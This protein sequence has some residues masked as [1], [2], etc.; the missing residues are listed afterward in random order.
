MGLEAVS[1]NATIQDVA[2]TAFWVAHFRA[3]ENERP[4][5]LFRDPYAQQ[6]AGARGKAFA[7]AVP[8]VSRYTEWTV[9]AR[10]VIIDRFIEQAIQEGVN[11]V[12]NL[13]AGLDARPYRMNLPQNLLW[14]EADYPKI[15]EYKDDVLSSEQPSCSLIRIAIDLA[16]GGKRRAFLNDYASDAK[17]VL[18]LTEGVIPYLTSDEAAALARDLFSQTRFCYWAVE[19]IHKNVYRYL[20]D[21]ARRGGLENSPF[22]FFPKEWYA[23]FAECGWIEKE[24]RYL[25]EIAVEFKRTMPIP[26]IFELISKILPDKVKAQA[27]RSSG[28]VLFKRNDQGTRKKF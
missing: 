8:K 5:P 11:A 13:G 19:Y 27:S 21:A 12:I 3:K 24:T 2:D 26:K 7:D 4:Q 23:F 17:S 20:K 6:L 22:K 1:E 25:G 15:I 18:I 10:T 14:I 28:F 9:L 16:D